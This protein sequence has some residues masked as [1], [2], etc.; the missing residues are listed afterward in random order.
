MLIP[1]RQAMAPRFRNRRHAGNELGA[2]VKQYAGRTDTVVLGLPRGGI[3]VA[4]EVARTIGVPL[5]VLVVRKLGVAGQKELAMGA[6]ASG[7]VCIVNDAVVQQ[8]GI[9][10]AELIRTQALEEMVLAN[11]ERT[12]RGDAL[13]LP[14]LDA[15]T[16]LVDDGI[17]T[18]STMRAAV[19]ALRQRRPARIVVAIPVASIE[20]SRPEFLEADEVVCLYSPTPFIAVGQHYEDFSSIS[21]EEVRALLERHS[22]FNLKKSRN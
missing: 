18:G 17:A 19:R 3:P 5:D 13:A 8:L 1:E 16:I 22:P 14:V 7:G 10:Q 11:R 12:Y 20:G 9:P 21:D 2:A 4:S 15:V 6:I